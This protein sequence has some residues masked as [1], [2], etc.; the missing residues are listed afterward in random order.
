MPAVFFF[1]TWHVKKGI[2]FTIENQLLTATIN[3]KGAELTSIISQETGLEYM[4]NGDPAFWAKHSPILFPIVGQLKNNTYLHQG[5]SYQLPRHGFA[6]ERQFAVQEQ[7]ED[8]ITFVL[9]DDEGST[10]VY[11]FSFELRVKYVLKENA[12]GVGYMVKNTG[13]ED[14]YFSIG[15]HPAFAVPLEKGLHYTDYYLS[16]EKKE[17][18]AR[19][20]ISPDGL[21][22]TTPQPFL[23]STQLALSK[24]LFAKDAVVF[25]HL[26][27]S[28]VS[29][30]SDKGK[31]GVRMDYP[32]F[33]FI[34]FWAAKNAD[35]VCI[36]PWCGI[37]DSV[38]SNQQLSE[39]EGINKLPPGDEFVR[40]WTV[41]VF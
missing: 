29:L 6:R 11:P 21:I 39:K 24:E 31:H 19:W 18:A 28:I 14:L 13:D 30:Q 34:G 27:S 23:N 9:H 1:L 17:T 5:K 8:E 3:A 35:F 26:G 25:K 32:G 12:L 22:E 7:K 20:P 40:S 4:W 36:E 16:F 38:N 2:M 41:T 10:K 33:P 37:A 15:A